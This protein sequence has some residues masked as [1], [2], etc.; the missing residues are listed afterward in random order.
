M[1][2]LPTH[3]FRS[4]LPVLILLLTGSLA[5]GQSWYPKEFFGIAPQDKHVAFFDEFD[6]NSQRW[7]LNSQYLEEYIQDG[8]F[9][10]ET[11]VQNAFT[12]WRPVPLQANANFEAEVRI[13]YV[14][15]GDRSL[16]G[17]TFGRDKRGN[18]YNFFFTPQ[19]AFKIA[20]YANGR[21]EDIVSWRNNEFLKRYRYSY[22]SL[23]VRQVDQQWY[24]F[25]NE[26]LVA[27]VPA[28]ELY[29]NQFGFTIGNKM[30]VEV[31][32]LK[33]YEIRTKDQQGPSITLIQPSLNGSSHVVFDQREQVIR[34][35]VVD[36][37][38]VQL[39]TIN[40]T[41]VYFSSDGEFAAS[42]DL[43]DEPYEIQLVAI[44]Q[45]QNRTKTTFTM[46]FRMPE[47]QPQH[48]LADLVQP[49]ESTRPYADSYPATATVFGKN[50]LLLIGVNKYTYWNRLHNAVKD[51]QDIQNLLTRY[52]LFD[53]ENVV[54]L[55][56][57][58]ATR[59]KI[60]E[61]FEELQ[62]KLGEN[63]NLLIYYAGHGYYDDRSTLGYWVPVNARP[64]KI[65]DFIRNSTVHDYLRTINAKNTLLIADACYAG[66]L[67][68]N[69]RG[70][71]T[72]G[73]KSRWAFTSG[74][75]EKVWDGQPGENSPFARYLINYL[76]DNRKA[77]LY[78]NEMID[79]VS[80]VVRQNTAQTPQGN[81]L[82]LA[83]N[84]GGI[85]IFQRRQ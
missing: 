28:R 48:Q 83:G 16:A 61:T 75:I 68:S 21:S 80:T 41:E 47:P 42:L 53:N 19:G 34:G 2:R 24:F 55:Y 60:L 35:K 84:E 62:D 5:H 82:S 76:R 44:D 25:I 71:I 9:Y 17:L 22:K 51:C 70:Q 79:A 36:P 18:E 56:N 6:G 11:L 52:Y 3:F 29:G 58:E 39:V 20:L 4:V 45:N 64:S 40:G 67:F 81:P 8:E 49:A 15:G 63:D 32:Y 12:K 59:E 77:V 72:V 7:D 27:Q 14:K 37:S 57:E 46:E 43:P 65:P 13:R 33:I 1:K 66:S 31:D 74:D 69:Y 23:T 10:C 54:T 78:A 38:G 26:E 30:A 73:A 85:F 50:Y